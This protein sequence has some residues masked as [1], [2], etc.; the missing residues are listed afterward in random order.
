MISEKSYWFLLILGFI[1]FALLIWF[2]LVPYGIIEYN[3]GVNFFTSSIFMVLTVIF[4]SYL[5]ALREKREWN[6]V[7]TWV[8]GMIGKQLYHV[9]NSL[10]RFIYSKPFSPAPSKEEI[11]KILEDLNEMQKPSLTDYA[12]NFY[13]P[14]PSD[15]ISFY[16]LEALFKLRGH[17]NDLEIKYFRFMEPEICI[18]LSKIQR[19][20][21][22]IESYFNLLK[23]DEMAQDAIEK[24]MANSVLEIMK[25]IYKLHKIGISIYRR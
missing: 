16:E 10:S 4:L 18:P 17:L 20:L 21:D 15:R 11:A 25:E 12:F 1:V 23:A 7:E 6:T 8:K 24:P 2:W 3:L 22:A 14:K 5:I 19:E 9:F 13:L